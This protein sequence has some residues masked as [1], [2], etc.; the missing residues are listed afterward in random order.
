MSR[1]QDYGF[2]FLA[3]AVCACFV[4][5]PASAEGFKFSDQDAENL[6]ITVQ[7]ARLR[8]SQAREGTAASIASIVTSVESEVLAKDTAKLDALLIDGD[9]PLFKDG[10]VTD[11]GRITFTTNEQRLHDV[12]DATSRVEI[13]AGILERQNDHF[14]KTWSLRAVVL[15]LLAVVGAIFVRKRKN[16]AAV[17]TSNE[18]R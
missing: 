8:A 9:R 1:R 18:N 5:V 15:I 11:Y 14:V 2:L 17:T 7:R 16:R 13:G 6:E 4:A 12:Y 3:C 10:H